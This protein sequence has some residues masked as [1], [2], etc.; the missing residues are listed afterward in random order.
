VTADQIQLQLTKFSRW[1]LDI[2]QFA[3][4]SGNTVN[5]SAPLY[6]FLYNFSRLLDSLPGGRIDSYRGVTK[7]HR[8]DL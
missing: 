1:N 2:S 7:R 5:D 8:L 4:A 3:K 6:D